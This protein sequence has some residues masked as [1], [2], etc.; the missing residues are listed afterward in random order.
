MKRMVCVGYGCAFAASGAAKAAS[1]SKAACSDR[2]FMDVP[3]VGAGIFYLLNSH[4]QAL[5]AQFA[6]RAAIHRREIR[7]DHVRLRKARQQPGDGRGDCST[8]ENVA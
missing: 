1:A 3:P 2:T 7:V 8:A 5:Q 6:D 4:R